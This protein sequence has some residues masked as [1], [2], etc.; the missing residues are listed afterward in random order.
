VVGIS[1]GTSFQII[2]NN[3]G[4]SNQIADCTMVSAWNGYVCK[5]ERIAQL[6]FESLDE[7]KE[8][9][10]VS[11]INLLGDGSGFNNK[12]NSFMDHCWD[13]HYTCQKRL[14]R[15]PGLIESNKK[16]EI[17]YTGTQPHNSRYVIQGGETGVDW[18]HLTIDFSQ[19]RLYNVY[20]KESGG[21]ETIIAANDFDPSTNQLVPISK[22]KCGE[23]VYYKPT[24][25]YEFYLTYG[26]TVR[27][28]ALDFLEGMVRLQISYSDFFSSNYKATF[29]DRLT[30]VLGIPQNQLRIV[31]VASGSTII[32]WY[33][34]SSLSTSQL[35]RKELQE[36]SDK[37]QNMNSQGTLDLGFPILDFTTQVVTNTGQILTG[38]SSEYSKKDVHIAVY[39][40]LAI[41][42]LSVLVAIVVAIIKGVK[43]TKAYNEV[44]NADT[45]A[46]EKGE[47]Q[48]EVS[49]GKIPDES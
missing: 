4:A 43:M 36:M 25:I 46:Y 29:I 31:S 30:S 44:A 1:S 20:A 47:N 38:S 27:F 2:P 33:A 49:E 24:F 37:L 40:I 22:S 9:R 39:I 45:I 3:V 8:D 42:A 41:A 11:P 18:L 12:L 34:T 10:T 21:T 35:Q 26:C 48:S 32:D 13:G 6:M 14:S 5:N 23:N 19:S 7:D 16:Y 17:Y 15:F 28:Q